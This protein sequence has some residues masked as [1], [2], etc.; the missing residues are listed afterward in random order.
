[1]CFIENTTWM[2]EKGLGEPSANIM[3]TMEKEGSVLNGHETTHSDTYSP[4][5]GSE[6]YPTKREVRYSSS[7]QKCRRTVG[8]VM[9]V[10]WRVNFS[11]YTACKGSMASHSH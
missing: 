4:G 11:N 7:T 8:D 9:L 10:P 2:M 1:M 3:D 5:N 6:T